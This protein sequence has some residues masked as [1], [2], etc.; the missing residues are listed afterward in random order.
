M[1]LRELV[2]ANRS[3][4]RYDLR[5]PVTEAELRE[6][7]DLGRLSASGGNRQPL[8]YLLSWTPAGNA[9]IF[10]C[11]AWAGYLK[12]WG[13]PS[14]S[15]R[16]AGYIVILCDAR[17]ANGP[18]HDAGIAAQ[19]ILLGAT[20]RGLGGCMIGAFKRE[21]LRA[22]LQ[23]PEHLEVALVLAI[24]KPSETIVLEPMRNEDVRYWR[25]AQ[26]VHHVPKRALDEIV[27]RF[28]PT[29]A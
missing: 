14:E 6:L 16:P 26:G 1:N 27:I 24:G 23:L 11:L 7:V 18:G 5:A 13:G 12:D 22:A 10:P 2:L 4:R 25:D 29:P 3:V 9:A 20:E 17:I 28:A 21:P 19:S 8:K 15:E